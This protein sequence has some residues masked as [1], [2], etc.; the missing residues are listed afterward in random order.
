MVAMRALTVIPGVAGSA[1]VREI[2][3][4]HEDGAV[5]VDGVAVGVCGT[6][7]EIVRGDLGEAPPG[8]DYLVLGHESVGRVTDDPTGTF[9]PGDLVVGIVRRPDPVP[10]PNCAAGEWDMCRNGRYTEHGIKGRHGYA[11]ERYRLDP[12]HTVRLDP[13]LESVGVLLEPASIVA[14]AWDHV[15]RISARATANP[16]TVLITGAGPI[17]MLAALLGVQ[18][19]LDIHVLDSVT[20]GPK[21]ELVRDLGAMYHNKMPDL[22]VDVVIECTGVPAVVFGA[23]ARLA[24]GG[25]AC[26]IGM[27]VPGQ[28]LELDGGD[29]NRRM[30]QGN[31]VVFGSIN[32]NRRHWEQ[33]AS[34][35]GAAELGWLERIITRRV[36]LASGADALA[37]R[38]G[39]VKVVVELGP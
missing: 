7:R 16:R 23:V 25:V 5:R 1:E 10:C 3:D 37:V 38:E 20:G 31:N 11:R 9:A 30:V 18:R 24:P 28:H 39:D 26:V 2:P 32:A 22:D 15:E 13:D 21:P 36:P 17:G 14:K 8:D 33:A 34:A 35:L 12:G 27:S 29:L 6:D 4:P 19:G